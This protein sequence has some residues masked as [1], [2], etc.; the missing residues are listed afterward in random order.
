MFCFY[1]DFPVFS[2]PCFRANAR[3]A[4]AL[5][6]FLSKAYNLENDELAAVQADLRL[7]GLSLPAL[8]KLY[9]RKFTLGLCKK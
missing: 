8:H 6:C 7:N 9:Y 3:V 5:V 2:H 1:L 4:I